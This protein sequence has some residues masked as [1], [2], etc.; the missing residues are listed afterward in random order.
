MPPKKS[1]SKTNKQHESTAPNSD[2]TAVWILD[3]PFAEVVSDYPSSCPGVG[4]VKLVRFK[5]ASLGIHPVPIKDFT[6]KAGPH[7]NGM[8]HGPVSVRSDASLINKNDPKGFAIARFLRDVAH[9]N[10][11]AD[12][13]IPVPMMGPEE[14]FHIHWSYAE[15]EED[16]RKLEAEFWRNDETLGIADFQCIGQREQWDGAVCRHFMSRSDW[17]SGS[18]EKRW[19]AIAEHITRCLRKRV[20]DDPKTK[21]E[22]CIRSSATFRCATGGSTYPQRSERSCPLSR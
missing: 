17:N 2:Q 3:Q 21:R 7:P 9:L 16:L 15:S 1:S 12:L 22:G 13:P 19:M 6:A 14:T 18:E 5:Y 4:F 8:S 11:D 20:H 10:S